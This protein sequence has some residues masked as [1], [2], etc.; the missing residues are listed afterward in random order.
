MDLSEIL[1]IS[2]K[3]GLYKVV[4]RRKNDLIVN[5]L[6]DGKRQIVHAMERVSSLTDISIYTH[7]DS[8]PLEEFFKK[9][10]AM[11]GGKALLNAN[12]D[13]ENLRKKLEEILP[14]YDQDRVY[15]S[16]IKKLFQWYNLLIDKGLLT[17]ERKEN[18]EVPS[19]EDNSKEKL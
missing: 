9:A 10:Y 3:P 11:E 2:G 14:N 6:V 15:N 18:N 8:V 5:S 17:F 1:S 16:D 7:E 12:A 4:S 19:K 13:P